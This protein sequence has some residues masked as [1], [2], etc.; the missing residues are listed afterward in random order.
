MTS[1]PKARAGVED[2][3]ARFVVEYLV[4][5]NATQAAERAGYSAKTARQQGSRLL[6]DAAIQAQIAEANGA[7]IQ[8]VE[9]DADTVLRELLRLGTIDLGDAFDSAGNL[10]P[11]KQM[12]ESVR[13]ALT[14]IEVETEWLVDGEG[15]TQTRV[16]KSATTKVRTFDKIRALELLGKHL[17]LFVERHQ[18]EDAASFASLLAQAFAGGQKSTPP[19]SAEHG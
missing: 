9:L 19:A 3:R 15:V 4:D 6:S 11:I 10:L 18:L 7:R 2:R 13:R 1:Q 12:P 5:L 16:P 8:R 14:G 17:K